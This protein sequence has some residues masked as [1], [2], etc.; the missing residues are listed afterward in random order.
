MRLMMMVIGLLGLPVASATAQGVVVAPHAIIVDHRTRSA[1]LTLYNPGSEPTEVSIATFY[2]YPVTDSVGDFALATP[3]EPDS[4]SAAGWIEAYPKRMVIGPLERQTVR[5]LARPPAALADGEYWSRVMI[6]ARGGTAP[7]AMADSLAPGIQVGLNLEVRTI[8][9]LQ[10]RK[11]ATRTAVTL[12]SIQV[13]P[14]G[15]SLVVRARMTRDG[16]AAFIGTARGTLTDSSDRL[17]ASF[18]V[19]V[20]VYRSV[21]P[22]F[23][24][25]SLG[26]PAGRYRLKVTLSSERVDLAADQLV[27]AEPVSGQVDVQLP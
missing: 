16:N 4:Q 17:V 13:A 9:P 25:S 6:T 2:G 15:D 7:V 5:L 12:D 10:Y 22:R 11:G 1:A 21:T 19:P 20:A 18:A 26:L 3:T 8:L 23:A 14:L 24:L 27:R